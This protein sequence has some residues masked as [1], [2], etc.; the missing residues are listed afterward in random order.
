VRLIDRTIRPL[1]ADCD[2]PT[3]FNAYLAEVRTVHRPKRDLMKLMDEL[4]TTHAP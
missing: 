1:F 4:Q 3:D 2:R